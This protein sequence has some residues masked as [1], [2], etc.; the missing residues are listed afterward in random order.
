MRVK[1]VRKFIQEQ[2]CGDIETEQKEEGA[3]GCVG[4]S[5][6][7][8]WFAFILFTSDSFFFLKQKQPFLFKQM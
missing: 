7:V 6:L 3:G 2:N 8:F 1:D 4:E 5:F